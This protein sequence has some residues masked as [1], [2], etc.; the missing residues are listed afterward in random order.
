MQIKADT[1]GEYVKRV[2]ADKRETI[3]RLRKIILENL[4]DGFKEEYSNQIK[5]HPDMGKACIRFK[6]P[7]QIP[8]KVTGDLVSKIT[9][10]KWL[11]KYE[12]NVI[13]K[14]KKI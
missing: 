8:D 9:V 13:S 1:P 10:D 7:E 12:K 14:P 6:K 2:R 5:H 4:P 11:N 3:N